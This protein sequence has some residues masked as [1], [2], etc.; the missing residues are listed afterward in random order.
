MHFL[1]VCVVGIAMICTASWKALWLGGPRDVVGVPCVSA[2]LTP[3][4]RWGCFLGSGPAGRI[5]KERGGCG[6]QRWT[7]LGG[8]GQGHS[9]SALGPLPL[10][11]V[12]QLSLG[13]WVES[14]LDTNSTDALAKHKEFPCA[15]D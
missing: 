5:W 4:P 10:Q 9:S 15:M 11:L 2:W 8:S 7:E 6:G 3:W 12:L 14:P 13:S 1:E